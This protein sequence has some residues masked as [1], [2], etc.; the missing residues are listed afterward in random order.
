MLLKFIVKII[1]FAEEILWFTSNWIECSYW[2]EF[3]N[4]TSDDADALQHINK[5]KKIG[6]G[7]III[8]IKKC[9]ASF[10]KDNFS[11]AKNKV[12]CR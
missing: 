11:P 10:R 5:Q 3:Y 12:F 6:E 4:G 9:D 7:M 8:I 1:F 2:I